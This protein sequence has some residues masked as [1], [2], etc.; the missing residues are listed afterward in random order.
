MAFEA[1]NVDGYPTHRKAAPLFDLFGQ[2][3]YILGID[4]ATTD[5]EIDSAF[6]AARDGGLVSEGSL[7]SASKAILSPTKRL[8]CELSY[9][10]DSRPNEIAVLNDALRSNASA[11]EL[12]LIANE[13][14]ALSRANF[15]A[16]IASRQPADNALLHAIVMSHGAI[17]S[18]EVH[19]ALKVFRTAAGWPAPSL[20]SV[21]QCLRELLDLH[22][23]AVLGGY[24]HIEDA[25]EPVLACTQAI[26]ASDDRYHI[27]ALARFLSVY[28]RS[29]EIKRSRAA[30][31]IENASDALRRRPKEARL[32]VVLSNALEFW[33]SLCSPLI[34]FDALHDRRDDDGLRGPAECVLMLVDDLTRSHHYTVAYQIAKLGR[35]VLGPAADPFDEQLRRIEQLASGGPI[36]RLRDLTGQL[37]A[38]PSSLIS[39]LEQSGFGPHSSEPAGRLREAFAQAAHSADRTDPTEPWT[40][41]RDL[42]MRLARAGHHAAASALIRGLIQQ[43]QADAAPRETVAM[44]PYDLSLIEGQK[45]TPPAETGLLPP[46]EPEEDAVQPI[47]KLRK[48]PPPALERPGR[49]RRRHLLKGLFLAAAAL[50]GAGFYFGFGQIPALRW[51]PVSNRP[52]LEGAAAPEAEVIPPVGTGQR[53]SLPFVRYCHFQAERLKTVKQLAQGPEDARAYNLLVVDYNARCSDFLY[54]S[55]DLVSVVAEVGANKSKIEADARRI[56]ST[57]PGHATERK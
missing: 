12:I 28:R 15:L 48:S 8:S 50:A 39:A 29:S 34:F 23:E 18:T 36:K 6:A 54:Q 17:D 20:L 47:Q 26:L 9:P 52:D 33:G 43:G 30:T 21:V 51:Q 37:G 24:D 2:P 57:W 1:A 41:L 19:A 25:A 35:D 22:A 10:L 38:E 5:L 14:A 4:P 7:V 3:F 31:L 53:Y 11:S 49:Q 55:Q 32:A 45:Q 13:L 16:H 44:L 46:S 56:I 27:E 42:A 40:L